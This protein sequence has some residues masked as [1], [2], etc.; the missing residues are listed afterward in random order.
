MSG[1]YFRRDDFL[2]KDVIDSKAVRTGKVKDISF[3]TSGH[4]ALAVETKDNAE[5]I[6]SLD[7]VA[8]VGDVILLKPEEPLREAIYQAP[9]APSVTPPP[10]QQSPTPI[11]QSVTQRPDVLSEVICPACN[12]SNRSGARFCRR[13]GARIAG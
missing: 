2:G 3:D 1:N 11:P 13:C 8:A 10:P 9:S 7:R 4:I 5:K 6:V 12:T